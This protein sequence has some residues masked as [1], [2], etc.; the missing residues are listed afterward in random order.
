MANSGSDPYEILGIA[1]NVSDAEL[2]A[3][4][5]SAVQRHHPD[6]NGGSPE[7]ARRFEEVQDAYARIRALRVT[8]PAAAARPE[9]DPNLD[10]RLDDIERELAAAREARERARRAAQEAA[11]TARQERARTGA[12]DE[13]LGYITTEDSFGKIFTD[14]AAGLSEHLADARRQP[15]NRAPGSGAA[16]GAAEKVADLLDDISARLRGEPRGR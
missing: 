1:A 5:R 15:P 2:R 11:S 3:A 12:S 13:E 6:H 16:A 9:R 7:S 10:S 4:Y 14:A 8:R